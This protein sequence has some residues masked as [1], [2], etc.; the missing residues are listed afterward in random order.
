MFAVVTIGLIIVVSYTLFRA[1][2]KIESRWWIH[3]LCRANTHERKVA[4]TFDDGMEEQMTP[5]VLDVL[6]KHRVRA[7]FFVV[8]N[9]IDASLLKRMV[10]EGHIVGNHTS[11]H[12]GMDPLRST[13]KMIHDA[14]Q[15]EDRIHSI[16][17]LRPRLFR[18]PFGVS[19]PMIGR[20]VRHMGY[21]VIGWSIRSFD[22]LS[23]PREVVVRRI[24]KRLHSG[25]IILLHDNRQ[26][27]DI[28]LDELLN[29]LK[30]QNYTV[31]RVDQLLG[32]NAYK[33]EN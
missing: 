31:E 4:L 20:M 16:T 7:C 15:T 17:G 25:A 3:A 32:I 21:T 30:K 18:P 33:N 5:K 14:Q 26:E 8:G 9:R 22:T 28:L 23:R 27:A 24:L 13:S 11:A 10:H 2:S 1:S 19:N 6:K 29:K 12:R